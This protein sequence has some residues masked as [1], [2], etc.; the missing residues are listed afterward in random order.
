MTSS[1]RSPSTVQTG[2]ALLEGIILR[3]LADTLLTITTSTS[4]TANTSNRFKL[5]PPAEYRHLVNN[6][7]IGVNREG[8]ICQKI[9]RRERLGRFVYSP[10]LATM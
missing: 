8:V 6:F 1:V 9:D 7:K 3:G 4:T 10:R 2:H 5:F